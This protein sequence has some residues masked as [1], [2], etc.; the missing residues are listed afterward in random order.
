LTPAHQIT[1]AAGTNS[2]LATTPPASI[3]CTGVLSQTSTPIRRSA[4][5]A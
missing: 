3:R 4:P 5:S 2:P 1:F